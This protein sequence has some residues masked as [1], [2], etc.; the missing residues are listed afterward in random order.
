MS[1]IQLSGT[2]GNY[3]QNK[4]LLKVLVKNVG[5]IIHQS[6]ATT[7]RP[8]AHWD[9]RIAGIWTLHSAKPCYIAPFFFKK[10]KNT[11]AHTN[12]HNAKRK[13]LWYRIKSL[14]PAR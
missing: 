10:K 9:R 7:P 2:A 12:T 1:Q 4:N 6:F 11:H 13:H 8:R 3:T 5:T 14:L